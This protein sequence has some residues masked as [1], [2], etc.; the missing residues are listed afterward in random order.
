MALA[1]C[2]TL[3]LKSAL[4]PAADLP[5]VPTDRDNYGDSFNDKRGFEV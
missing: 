1:L 5:A 4:E 3:Q 2:G